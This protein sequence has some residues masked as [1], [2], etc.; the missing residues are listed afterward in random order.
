MDFNKRQ[1]NLQKMYPKN[2]ITPA[3]SLLQN[4]GYQFLM[5]DTINKQLY[6]VKFEIFSYTRITEIRNIK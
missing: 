1:T 2:V 3:S 5:E 6:V 4:D